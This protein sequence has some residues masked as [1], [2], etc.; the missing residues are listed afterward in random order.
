MSFTSPHYFVSRFPVDNGD[1]AGEY[2]KMFDPQPVG[3]NLPGDAPLPEPL[4]ADNP[5]PLVMTAAGFMNRPNPPRALP[6]D[7]LNGL[8]LRTWDNAKDLEFFTIGFPGNRLAQGGTYPAATVRVPRGA[9]FH[10]DMRGKGPPPHTIH[11]HGIEPTPVNDGVGHCSMELGHTTYQWQPN[12]IGTY[13]YH[14]HRNTMQHFEFGLFGLLLIEPPDTFWASLNPDLTL[15]SVP[16]GH[17]SDGKRRIATNLALL[18]GSIQSQFPGFI[19]GNPSAPDFGINSAN[20]WAYTV[21]Y[22]VEALWVVDDRDSVWSDLGSNAFQTFP[23]HGDRPGV[24]DDFAANASGGAKFF[25]FNDFNA[26]YWFVTGV[27]VPA[28]KG[29][30]GTI[31]PAGVPPVGGGLP[32][33]LI[34]PELN[35]GISGTQ[36]AV[37]AQVGQTILVRCLDAAYNKARITFPV[38]VVINAWDGRALGVPPYGLYN[39][40]FVLPANTPYEISTARRFEALIKANAPNSTP[41]KVEFLDTRGSGLLMTALIPFNIV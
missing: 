39:H 11:W 22:D 17:C 27:P 24:N 8:T 21:P 36:I 6:V 4:L 23:K 35:S 26:D 15:N 12:F 29:G 14:C 31:N 10:G 32:G 3:A 7:L 1:G 33:G 40:P 2:V 20:P 38:D 34:P 28:P 9:I 5:V 37:N 16:I 30:I 13:F 19:G 41:A 18:P 25:A